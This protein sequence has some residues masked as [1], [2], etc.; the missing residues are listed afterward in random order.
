MHGQPGDTAS[1]LPTVPIGPVLAPF[2]TAGPGGGLRSQA[3]APAPAVLG[4][5][6][7]S[8]VASEMLATYRKCAARHRCMDYALKQASFLPAVRASSVIYMYITTT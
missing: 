3:A 5:C 7:C 2:E 4:V 6:G 8:H 1:W